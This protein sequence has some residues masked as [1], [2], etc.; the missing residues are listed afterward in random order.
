MK[1]L[2]VRREFIRF[3]VVGG[4]GFFVDGGLLTTLMQYGWDV[5][6]ARLWSFPIAVSVTW[7]LNR[8]WTFDSGSIISIRREYA[9]Y[10]TTQVIGAAINLCV[11]FLL[12][13]I[14]SML[15]DYPLIPLAAGA[16]VSLAVNYFLSKK[17]V[18][19]R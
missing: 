8:L 2:F 17:I 7:I 1:E 9:Y 14:N 16:A 12:I 13:R 3:L 15:R 6:P 4:I 11:F 10:F 19:K 18:F 5:I